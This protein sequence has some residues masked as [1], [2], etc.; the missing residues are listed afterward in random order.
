MYVDLKL[1][2]PKQKKKNMELY[3]TQ[4]KHRK[5]NNRKRSRRN[6][7]KSKKKKQ[8]PKKKTNNRKSNRRKL[9]KMNL[10]DD[11]FESDTR[12]LS[13]EQ[14]S[15]YHY[16]NE[17]DSEYSIEDIDDVKPKKKYVHLQHFNTFI[18]THTYYFINVYIII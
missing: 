10:S 6:I 14:D 4:Q 18:F 5:R 9:N 12:T 2:L 3:R 1:T 11:S 15:D 17:N 13:I 8:K 7:S 16:S